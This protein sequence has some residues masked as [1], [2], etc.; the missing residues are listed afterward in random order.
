VPRGKRVTLTFDNGP[1]PG[2]TDQVLDI[3][4]ERSLRAIFFVVANRVEGTRQ[5]APCSPEWLAIVT[6][7]AITR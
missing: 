7:W 1:T 4:A 2:V 5:R 3:L 6:G